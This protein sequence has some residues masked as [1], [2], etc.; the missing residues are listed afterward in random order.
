MSCYYHPNR[1]S[2]SICSACGQTT[3]AECIHVTGTHPMCRH[4]WELRISNARAGVINTPVKTKKSEKKEKLPIE[5]SAPALAATEFIAPEPKIHDREKVGPPAHHVKEIFISNEPPVQAKPSPPAEPLINKERKILFDQEKLTPPYAP[6]IDDARVVPAKPVTKHEKSAEGIIYHEPT[7]P[8]PQIFPTD[9]EAQTPH[10]TTEQVIYLGPAHA[11]KPLY[12]ETEA[13]ASQ[14]VSEQEVKHDKPK[15]KLDVGNRAR[16]LLGS[17]SKLKLSFEDQGRQQEKPQYTR[18]AHQ[19]FQCHQ[20]GAKNDTGTP[21]CQACG[22]WF[23]H[24]ETSAEPQELQRPRE[25]IT[26]DMQAAPAEPIIYLEPPAQVPQQL[27]VESQP[28]VPW[29][30]D[31]QLANYEEP[32]PKFDLGNRARGLFGSL[33]KPKPSSGVKGKQKEGRHYV[34]VAHQ[35]FQ[36][37]QCGAEN[38]IGELFCQGCGSWFQYTCPGCGAVVD[39]GF[40]SCPSCLTELGWGHTAEEEYHGY[41]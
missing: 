31:E 40:D 35:T 13:Q 29:S 19:T 27:Y 20:C 16:G 28:Q 5:K 2:V 26:G 17:L 12:V 22:T 21:F 36:C 32:K 9:T 37:H 6:T 8:A 24:H 15:F 18:V 14:G 7:P 10:A 39:R 25:P 1:D 23:Q 4:C 30:M 38:Y 11:P 41:P 33:F 3:C 34:Q